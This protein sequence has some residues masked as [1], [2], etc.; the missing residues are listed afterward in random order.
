VT[1][2]GR[3]PDSFR[4]NYPGPATARL[5]PGAV[6][7]L[8]H[9]VSEGAIFVPDRKYFAL[10]DNRDRSSDSRYWG[11]VPRENIIGKPV[12][13]YWSYDPI[14]DHASTGIGIGQLLHRAKNL[15]R[16]TRWDRTAKI[17]RSYPLE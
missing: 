6:E 7:M 2:R 12:M 17:V 16:R 5:E 4:D 11:F 1:Y 14:A 10:G 13:I 15:V 9:H 8:K 3:F